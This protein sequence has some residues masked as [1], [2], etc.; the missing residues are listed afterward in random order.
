[1]QIIRTVIWIAMT[2]LLV[3]FIAMNWER[4]PV[5]FWPLE[6][7]YL[8]FEWPVG[9]IALVFFLLGL[10]PMWLLHRAGKWRLN[11]RI[12]MLETNVRTAA[13]AP[14]PPLATTTQLDAQQAVPAPA[15]PKDPAA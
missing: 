15:I 1:M 6:T 13:A 9:V 8:H 5:N 4:A 14:P 10:L 2:A 3:M 7:G 11:R 12:S